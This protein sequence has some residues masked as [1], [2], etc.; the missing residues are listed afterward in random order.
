MKLWYSIQVLGMQL[1]SDCQHLTSQQYGANL[2]THIYEIYIE[3][4]YS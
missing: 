3:V 2:Y 1:R 4:K